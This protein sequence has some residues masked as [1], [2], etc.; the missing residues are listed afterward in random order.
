MPIRVR[1]KGDRRRAASGTLVRSIPSGKH[2]VPPIPLAGYINRMMSATAIADYEAISDTA[3]SSGASGNNGGVANTSVNCLY[4]YYTTPNMRT[5]S[6]EYF[7]EPIRWSILAPASNGGSYDF[8][9]AFGS[10]ASARATTNTLSNPNNFLGSIGIT[11]TLLPTGSHAAWREGFAQV[12]PYFGYTGAPFDSTRKNFTHAAFEAFDPTTEVWNFNKSYLGGF[13]GGTD[14]LGSLSI[15]AIRHRVNG[16][17]VG[18]LILNPPIYTNEGPEWRCDV[19]YDDTYEIDVWYR[20]KSTAYANNP[21]A[22]GKACAFIATS[23]VHNSSQKTDYGNQCL[24]RN[25]DFSPAFNYL[26]QTY[27]VTVAGHVGWTLK[28]GSDGPHKMQTADGWRV[29]FTDGQTSNHGIVVWEKITNDDYVKAI[30]LRYDREIAHVEL[31]AGPLMPSGISRG[32]VYYRIDDGNTVYRS[33]TTSVVDGTITHATPGLFNQSGTS[34]F[35]MVPWTYASPALGPSI[36]SS[37]AEGKK[38]G[39]LS[40]FL[41]LPTTITLTR[42]NQ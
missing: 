34:V 31:Y 19:A 17:A 38:S 33:S 35:T 30:V 21:S 22:P 27:Q 26:E 32:P 20:I 15:Y 28:G 23:M 40:L 37:A 3:W 41:E 1:Q 8:W 29:T 36:E 18:D 24:F 39:L 7:M 6:A 2:I 4:H 13:P 9:T 14:L 42:V 11:D 10:I 25:V 5:T 16:V 12:W